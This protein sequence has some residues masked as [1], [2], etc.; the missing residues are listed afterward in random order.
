MSEEQAN[1][2]I[3]LV[4]DHDDLAATIGAFLEDSGFAMDYA[5]DGSIA[6]N[7]LEDNHYDMIIL[8]LMLPKVDGMKVCKKL[9]DRGDSTPILMLT[10]RDQL[11]DKL[12]GFESGADD[13]LVKPFD[14]EELSARVNALIRRARGEVS[15][16]AIKI[17]DLV[18][19]PRTMRV[20]RD[21][22]RL[23]LSPT[24]I[25]ILRILMRESPRLVSREQ[26]ENELWGDMLPDSDT[27]RSHMYNLRKSIDRPFETK[28]LHTVQGMGFKLAHPDDA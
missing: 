3:L 6:L 22:K 20:E 10:A 13:Y 15:D 17:G 2:T 14:M 16:G 11:E 27:L 23:N 25:R 1:A 24:S 28:L 9:R 8:D 5:A 19:D 12:E 4:E 21:N 18:F 7:L 26:L